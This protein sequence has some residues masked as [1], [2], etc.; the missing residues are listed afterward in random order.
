MR[1]RGRQGGRS[2]GGARRPNAGGGARPGRGRGRQGGNSV[3]K[4]L[5]P[6][7]G[8]QAGAIANA[9]ASA[10]YNPEIRNLRQEAKGS[11][12]RERDLGQ[13]YAQLAADYQGATSAGSD[14]LSTLAD[15]TS[16]QLAEAGDRSS[17]DATKLAGE[18][19]SFAKLVGGPKDTE[20]LAKIAMAGAAAD[21]ARVSAVQPTLAEQANFVGRLGSEKTAARMQGIESRQSERQRR[22]KINS[23]RAGK[24]REKGA[25]RVGKKE[26]I[27]QADRG[28]VMDRKQLKL[29]QKEAAS[30]ERQAAADAA[31]AR[32]ESARA[33]EQD[34]ITARQAQERIGISRKNAK[35]SAKSQRATAR[36]Y[37]EDNKEKGGLST[38]EKRARG[39]H[40]ADAMGAAKALLGIK[41]PKNAQQWSQFEAALIEKLG[42]SYA[43]EAARA[44]AK[45]RKQQAAKRRG[46][47]DRRVRKG[48]V[49]GPPT[50]RG[51]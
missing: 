20:G 28:Y 42:S 51:R 37:K 43:A 6:H 3:G 5:G 21:R 38:A 50:P 39:E 15:T 29:Q 41:V 35:T 8:N 1:G 34:S 44:V 48:E 17:A 7:T 45:L 10:E 19:D 31:L 13:W 12:K 49:A 4:F 32:I 36:N 24:Q 11:R 2:A 9:E 47:Y 40:S 26:E 14:A 18:D 22:E 33:A 27:R 23:E 46:G 30:A 25:A 16:K